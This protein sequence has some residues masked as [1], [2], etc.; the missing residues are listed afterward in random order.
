MQKRTAVAVSA[1]ITISAFQA[2][3]AEGKK[4]IALIPG[5]VAP[6]PAGRP[7]AVSHS[8]QNV[9]ALKKALQSGYPSTH[10][11]KG[12]LLKQKGDLDA[13]L[14][15]FLK[16]AQ[17]NPGN[18]RAFYEQALIFKTK[19]YAKLA[20]SA[21]Q[22]ALA[23]RPDFRDARVLLASVFLDSG[24]LSAAARELFASLGLPAADKKEK[25]AERIPEPPTKLPTLI[26]TPHGRMKLPLPAV[27]AARTVVPPPISEPKTSDA[28]QDAV[29]ALPDITSLLKGIPGVDPQATDPSAAF[30]NGSAQSAPPSA[31]TPPLSSAPATSTEA[32]AA[33]ASGTESGSTNNGGRAATETQPQAQTNGAVA[34]V[35]GDSGLR[36]RKRRVAAWLDS[37]LDGRHSIGVDAA[38]RDEESVP[39]QPA[40]VAE[41]QTATQ[42]PA[43]VDVAGLFRKAVAWLPLPMFKPM[44]ANAPAAPQPTSPVRPFDLPPAAPILPG[45][46]VA[47]LPTPPQL[48]P[49][50]NAA[51][52]TFVPPRLPG[53]PT[54]IQP[55]PAP[56]PL[57]L[58]ENESSNSALDSV[59]S[60]LP[61]DL[62]A[63]VQQI[64]SPKPVEIAS[65][66][67]A[68]P[69]TV[70]RVV[71]T[72]GDATV[73]TPVPAV[74]ARQPFEQFVTAQTKT[75][76]PLPMPV[77]QT[78]ADTP[79]PAPAVVAQSGYPAPIPAAA[80]QVRG[81][82]AP[83]PVAMPVPG[84][85]AQQ[86]HVPAPPLPVSSTRIASANLAPPSLPSVNGGTIP[87]P[88]AGA[89]KVTSDRPLP[90]P[91]P[92]AS[93]GVASPVPG[94]QNIAP[95]AAGAQA[96]SPVAVAQPEYQ[97][98]SP[99]PVSPNPA[100]A[101]FATSPVAQRLASHGFKFVAP[102]LTSKQQYVVN[103]A[104]TAPVM[105][106]IPVANA[107]S[108]PV[109]PPDDDWAKKMKFLLANGTHSLGPGEA[110]M[111]SEETGEGV[112]FLKGGGSVRRKI[113]APR[114]AQEVARLRRPELL[115]PQGELQYNL[116]LLGKI[117]LPQDAQK[118]TTGPKAPPPESNLTVK[119]LLNRQ[120]GFVGW[121]KSVFKL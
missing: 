62:A 47:S 90:L 12:L 68:A 94:V 53:A 55:A 50:A 56:A 75:P 102:S 99:A 8:V 3:S 65:P 43:P 118:A 17:E 42:P 14:L 19:G 114:D 44:V 106:A 108:A 22:Q 101:S 100:Q 59:L 95:R 25:A 79:A 54:A 63:T 40:Q 88:G 7:L 36:R 29:A 72:P 70:Q 67:D 11:Q 81:I 86:P 34:S 26:Q 28:F 77:R 58:P 49:Q 109:P 83:A 66:K 112:L 87:V 13:A 4:S 18:V 48:G 104:R 23:V 9:A 110:F 16:A 107:K 27:T 92:I 97:Y 60:M 20:Q 64:I 5:L 91:I 39:G 93:A 73:P 41:G 82:P 111:F 103:T 2:V 113:A 85:S 33:S 120:D 105:K 116:S 80:P 37:F 46:A 31:S 119:D 21:V 69:P 115:A 51:I 121:F 45:Q 117:I 24:D 35:G 76:V 61:K 78:P 57:P 89:T 96:P 84:L 1:I 10:L 52:S 15:E 32:A 6:P 71:R 38:D 98:Q 74:D 30:S